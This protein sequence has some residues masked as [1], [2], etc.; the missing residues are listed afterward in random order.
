MY[1]CYVCV[2][3]NIFYQDY[4]E[5]SFLTTHKT[6]SCKTTADAT[7]LG[8]LYKKLA[9]CPTGGVGSRVSIVPILFRKLFAVLADAFFGS[10]NPTLGAGSNMLSLDSSSSASGNPNET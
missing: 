2:R 10:E 8:V 1:A 5:G 6:V 4:K 7:V 9:D 3:A